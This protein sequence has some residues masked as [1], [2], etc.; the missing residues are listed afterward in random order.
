LTFF[1]LNY[2]NIKEFRFNLFKKIHEICLGSNG[3][4]GFEEVYNLP[5]F[6]KNFLFNE[7]KKLYEATSN[8]NNKKIDNNNK[9]PI[10]IPEWAQDKIPHY[11]TTN[12]TQNPQQRGVTKR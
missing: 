8:E 10:T 12:N 6:I 11:T 7:L 4:Y 5:V 1:G 2:N 9:L 3:A